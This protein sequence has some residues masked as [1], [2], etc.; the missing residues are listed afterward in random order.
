MYIKNNFG[1]VLSLQFNIRLGVR[2]VTQLCNNVNYIIN[3]VGKKIN[4]KNNN[5]DI[6][7]IVILDD[8]VYRN[9]FAPR[10]YI[11]CVADLWS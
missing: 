3:D 5:I 7:L 8:I 2:Y 11:S 4:K 10:Y 9:H 6:I 1:C